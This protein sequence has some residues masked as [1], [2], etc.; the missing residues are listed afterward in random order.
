LCADKYAT[1]A[2]NIVRHG[3]GTA[4]ATG[5][6][7]SNSV[8]SESRHTSTSGRSRNNSDTASTQ[9]FESAGEEAAS[10]RANRYSNL[11]TSALALYC[12][13]LEMF[14]Q[15]L[16][17][18]GSFFT[19]HQYAPDHTMKSSLLQN[20]VEASGF[21]GVYEV[22]RWTKAAFV[23]YFQKTQVLQN[24]ERDDIQAILTQ[25]STS[26]SLTVTPVSESPL[27]PA[28]PPSIPSSPLPFSFPFA[29]GDCPAKLLYQW[30]L[31]LARDGGVDELQDQ[32]SSA[33]R[34]YKNA[35]RLF[36]Q[37]IIEAASSQD[38]VS[39]HDSGLLA[40]LRKTVYIR[41][42]PLMES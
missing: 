5:R 10:H 7:R 6:S 8:S 41:L 37:L 22:L 9:Q 16:S 17:A 34:K 4:T 39:Q 40:T 15:A 2:K 23:V 28:V 19:L 24:R 31:Q 20:K 14:T 36:E 25:G 35:Y 42:A 29:D 13:A 38:A 26:S 33:V 27:S 21:D 30:A 1:L 11:V 3:S 12:Q 32:I 18:G